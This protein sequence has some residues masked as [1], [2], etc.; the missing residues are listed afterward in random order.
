MA[1]NTNILFVKAKAKVYSNEIFA[2]VVLASLINP[3]KVRFLSQG[4]KVTVQR[5]KR[6]TLNTVANSEV[7]STAASLAALDQFTKPD[8]ES[9]E[10]APGKVLSVGWKKTFAD[11][12]DMTS[13]SI[14]LEELTAV[15]SEHA[16]DRLKRFSALLLTATASGAALPAFVKG[17]TKVWDAISSL[18]IKTS[19][20]D[21]DYLT[22]Q[23]LQDFVIFGSS[24]VAQSLTKE[25]GT[26]F[27]QETAIAQTGFKSKMGVNGTAFIIVPT[28]TAKQV[29]ICHKNAIGFV[30]QQV[31]KN[32]KIDLGLTEFTGQFAL[33]YMTVVDTAR[34]VKI[35][36]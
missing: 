21:D 33:D 8:W 34:L 32:A 7:G 6:P 24:E 5:K 11:D 4:I 9:I 35:S 10:T 23:G 1:K 26:V 14:H 31:K 18:V 12:Y 17:D 19:K 3:L 13:E 16:Y 36:A 20:V 29:V 22:I 15:M 30:S 28:F 25:M 2:S 27:N